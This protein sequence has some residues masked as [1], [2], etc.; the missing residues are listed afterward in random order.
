MAPDAHGS[1]ELQSK[2]L[3]CLCALF[4]VC[5]CVC[6]WWKQVCGGNIVLCMCVAETVSRKGFPADTG[7]ES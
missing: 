5:V 6:V 2:M 7:A 1:S 3:V 4:Y